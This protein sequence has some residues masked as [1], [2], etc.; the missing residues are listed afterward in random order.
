[1]ADTTT[2]SVIDVEGLTR[3]YRV[4]VHVVRAL[5]GISL[6]IRRGEFVAVMGPSGS[7]KSTFMNIVGCLDRPTSGHYRLEG[8]DVADLSADE[9]AEIRNRKIGFV[10]QSFNLLPR[11]SALANVAL[12]LLYDGSRAE[13]RQ[14]RAGAKL[15]LVGLGGREHHRPAQL[16]GGEQQR[17][18]I[19]RAL[20]NDPVLVLADEPTGNLDTRTSVEVMAQ[21]QALNRAG[22]TVLLVTHE[23]DIAGYA[24]RVLGFRDGRLVRDDAVAHPLDARMLARAI[25][26]GSGAA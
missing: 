7:G 13:E 16:S 15:R 9:R 14:E 8:R 24:G 4:G 10:F 22:I 26:A 20:V 17:V 6:H 19:A 12:P 5:R 23:E 21:L 2:D 1:M 25:P 18:A 3:D 11:H